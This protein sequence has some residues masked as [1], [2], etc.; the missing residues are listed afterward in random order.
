VNQADNGTRNLEIE[1]LKYWVSKAP[2]Y[3]KS[4][5]YC[6]DENCRQDFGGVL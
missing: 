6:L 3:R 2:D 4:G 1:I 5:T